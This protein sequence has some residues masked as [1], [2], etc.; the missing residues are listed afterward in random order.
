MRFFRGYRYLIESRHFD[1]SGAMS[2]PMV[3]KRLLEETGG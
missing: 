1:E 3:W 2:E